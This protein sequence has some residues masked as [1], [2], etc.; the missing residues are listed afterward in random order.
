LIFKY[1]FGV[2]IDNQSGPRLLKNIMNGD[3]QMVLG[4]LQKYPLS[5][6]SA[7]EVSKRAAG[8]KRFLDNHDWAKPVLQGLT[9]QKIL[10]VDA[11]GHYRIRPVKEEVEEDETDHFVPRPDGPMRDPNDDIPFSAKPKP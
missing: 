5:F 9:L 11:L 10:E 6:V 8:K 4:Y 1:P 7:M 3:D 2:P